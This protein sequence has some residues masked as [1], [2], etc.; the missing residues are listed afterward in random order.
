MDHENSREIQYLQ[1]KIHD[2]RNEPEIVDL[3]SLRDWGQ[4]KPKLLSGCSR[5]FKT[6][7]LLPID[8]FLWKD[9]TYPVFD[10]PQLTSF[11]Q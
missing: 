5:L 11:G 3:I 9:D 8:S 4:G 2:K 7:P 1:L 6:W 10:L